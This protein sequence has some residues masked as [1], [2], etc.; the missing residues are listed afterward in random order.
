MKT[1]QLSQSGRSMVE[2]LSVLAVIGVL[3]IG[4]IQGYTYAMNK[5]R[6]NTTTNDINLRAVDLVIQAS[7]NHNLSLAEWQS[8]NT[9]Y[10]F[11]EP[12]YTE[13]NLIAL[14]VG[15]E[16]NSIS[17]PVCEMIFED[18]KGQTQYIDIN[19]NEMGDNPICDTNN[20]MTFYFDNSQIPGNVY[21]E[22]G[23]CYDMGIPVHTYDGEECTTDEDCADEGCGKCQNKKCNLS[24]YQSKVCSLDGMHDGLCQWGEC[25]KRGCDDNNPCRGAKEYC[26]SPNTSCSDRFPNGETGVCVKPDFTRHVINGSVY[27]IS[28]TKISW[29]DADAACKAIGANLMDM[30][31]FMREH[32]GGDWNG[33]T[34]AHEKT[35]LEIAIKDQIW[36]DYGYPWIW[37]SNHNACEAYG[38]GLTGGNVYKIN[39][40]MPHYHLYSWDYSLFAVCQ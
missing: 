15:S 23:M 35:E 32:G 34:G 9:I 22:D 36:P 11:G 25:V 10:P 7:Q 18:M 28:N 1:K 37:T 30:N 38:V 4:S 21:C 2:M 27:Y 13:D 8:V 17:K 14:D 16:A 39:R 3:S 5:Y 26:S 33:A 31:A 20:I 6:A 24:A 29:W 40:N 19:G 12:M